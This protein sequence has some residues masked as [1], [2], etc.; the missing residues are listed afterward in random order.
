MRGGVKAGDSTPGGGP[1]RGEAGE[2]V[3]RGVCLADGWE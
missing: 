2:S 1:A 3:Q